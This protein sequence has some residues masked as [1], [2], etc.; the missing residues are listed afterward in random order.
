[1]IRVNLLHPD[2][3]FEPGPEFPPYITHL[4]KDLELGVIYD[5]MAQG[6]GFIRD[7]V[8]HVMLHMLTDI[9]TI[10]Y[11]QEVLRDLIGNP[12]LAYR[13]YEI[14]LEYLRRKK[15]QWL[16]V[17]NNP[18]PSAVLS[19]SRRLLAA[20]VDLLRGLR[21]IADGNI[22][23]VKSA[24]L[25]GF[26][27]S[28][29]KELDDDYLALLE[30]EIRA[31]RFP[32]GVLVSARLGPGNLG[33]DYLL[34]KPKSAYA[35][36][37]KRIFNSGSPVYSFTLHPRDDA[38]FRILGELRDRGLVRAAVAVAQA[39]DYM[40]S[41]FVTLRW[42]LAFYLGCLNLHKK[43]A[44]LGE[45]TAFPVPLP[46]GERRFHCTELYNPSLALVRGAKVVGNDL[47]AEGVDL[48][49]ITGPNRGGKTV[50]LCSVGLAQVMMQCGMFV[51]ASSYVANICT[52]LF[53]HFRREED[54]A[55]ESGK[56]E[57]ELKRISMI[58]DHLRPEALVLFNESFAATN[59]RE[60][61]EIAEQI[62]RALLDKRVEV[63]YVTHL[64]AFARRVYTRGDKG[65]LFLRAER[66]P[67]GRRTFKIKKGPLL[68]TSYGV[69]LFREVFED[70][71]PE[72]RSPP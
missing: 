59:E 68:E 67:D 9:E 23:T 61:S 35:N 11:R 49:I 30:R 45:P 31:L 6:D 24:G 58:V 8:R 21:A 34:R 65:V 26:F 33:T 29:Q 70:S 10:L 12:D 32:R 52:G 51:P 16:W 53:T 41:F 43:L 40:E 2:R 54:E 50:F 37:L 27:S 18:N 69:D 42:E 60:G 56:L 44:D 38:G 64:H 4:E 17:P 7:V 20:S 15:E 63:F 13:L 66:L 36:P 48:S 25:K 62:V 47:S 55:M 1:M 19:G 14:P 3:P 72:V 28:I 71:P 46:R 22:G 5:A 39:A 57:E